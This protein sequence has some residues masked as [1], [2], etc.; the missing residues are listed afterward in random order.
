MGS[1]RNACL[2]RGMVASSRMRLVNSWGEREASEDKVEEKLLLE[3]EV[4]MSVF[5][6]CFEGVEPE[7]GKEEKV[8]VASFLQGYPYILKINED[9]I[10]SF[11]AIL[12]FSQEICRVVVMRHCDLWKQGVIV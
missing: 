1:F 6:D 2:R 12:E 3:D 4:D 5:A 9:F 8:W 10:E 7:I 11:E